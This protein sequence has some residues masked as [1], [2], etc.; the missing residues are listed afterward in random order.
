M[1]QYEF[2][3]YATGEKR[4]VFATMRH[5]PP[6]RIVFHEHLAKN[7]GDLEY[8]WGPAEGWRV[9]NVWHRIF[10]VPQ[11]CAEPSD[12]QGYPFYSNTLPRYL[13]GEQH[14]SIGRPMV[15]NAKHAKAIADYKG[16]AQ[17]P[18]ETLATGKTDNLPRK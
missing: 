18:R 17:V 13:P 8:L 7:D 9:R 5:P 4:T 6:E 12:H 14:D 10:A 16:W 1:P 3:N 11:I 15:K 2:I